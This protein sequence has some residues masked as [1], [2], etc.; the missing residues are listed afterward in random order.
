M[1]K[2]RGVSMKRKILLLAIIA[3]LLLSSQAFADSLSKVGNKITAESPVYFNGK[4]LNDAII[5]D[6]TS[7]APLRAI[8]EELGI[9]V[10]YE[11]NKEGSVIN[12]T[13]PEQNSSKK[14]NYDEMLKKTTLKTEISGAEKN[15]EH[16][17]K[18]IDK[19]TTDLEG[20]TNEI[21]IAVREKEISAA[22]QEIITE[23]EN[24]I[25]YTNELLELESAK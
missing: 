24:I 22:R 8:A 20:K 13:S 11:K 17:S 10:K 3:I 18:L 12:L 15:I 25:K 23:Q 14:I 7:Y 21:Y 6:G 4:Q 5:T 19:L 9:D 2:K 16:L 1:D